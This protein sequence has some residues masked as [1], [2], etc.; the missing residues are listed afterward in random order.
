MTSCITANIEDSF[1]PT[2]DDKEES[3][4]KI[5][6]EEALANLEDFLYAYSNLSDTKGFSSFD[7]KEPS[8]IR[9]ISRHDISTKSVDESDCG[10]D[11]DTLIYVVNFKNDQGFA[12]MAAD[13][14][15]E[16]I[17]AIIDEGN[18]DEE[19]LQSEKNYGFLL[20]MER[21]LD[22][23][24]EDIN[25]H[26]EIP[27]TKTLIT[28]GYSITNQHGPLLHT[29]WDQENIYGS[30][31]PNGK[32]GCV[33][34]AVAQILSYYQTI[35]SVNWNDN[36]YS[37]SASL[38][39]P[40][41]IEDCDNNNGK[42]IYSDCVTSG[43]EIANLVRYLGVV[44]NAEYE[45]NKTSIKR[46][47]AISWFND[48]GGLS[49]TNLS[50]YNQTNIVNALNN[51]VLVYARGNAGRKRVL[52]ITLSYTDGHAWVY[53]GTITATKNGVSSVFLH[54]NWGWNGYKNGYYLGNAFNTTTGAT[55][56]DSTDG[57]VG[58]MYNFQYN[59]EYSIVSL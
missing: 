51:N 25:E 59:L 53:D 10:L 28:S 20:F 13:K 1:G 27:D 56:Y 18:F 39:W 30:L 19:E 3:Y 15:T 48:W 36:G 42:L 4:Y 12:I 22:M 31:C 24:D 23:I 54:C 6:E 35:N 33:A 55:I 2:L 21:A 45:S 34:I 11:N 52:G 43:T 49:A 32:G 50:D 38:H 44:M 8:D 58:D 26:N 47:K 9:V 41:I 37:G 40:Q 16:P 57:Q 7:K 29:K 17:L 14:R 46:K 5:S